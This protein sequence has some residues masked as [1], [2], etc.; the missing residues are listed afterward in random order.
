MQKRF[1]VVILL[2]VICIS[3]CVNLKQDD[4]AQQYER[5]ILKLQRANTEQ[6]RFYALNDAVKESYDSEKY[7][8]AQNYAEELQFLSEKFLDD[9]NY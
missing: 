8:E 3:G 1:S 2:I 9:W 6:E 7:D 5:A 4:S